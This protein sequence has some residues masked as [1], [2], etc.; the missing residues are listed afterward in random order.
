MPT[1]KYVQNDTAPSIDFTV[2]RAGSA[3]DLTGATVKFKIKR[4]D[5]DARTND[6]N[7]TC[8]VNSATGGTCTYAFTS[9][10][11]PAATTYSCDLEITHASGKVETNPQV[12]KIVAR[13]EA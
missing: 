6:S 1:L 8:T 9:G 2:T 5:T 7:N 13:E 10:D 4:D 3:V 12:V 11:L